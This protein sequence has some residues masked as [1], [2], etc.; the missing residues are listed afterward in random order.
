MS[1]A[2]RADSRRSGA[3]EGGVPE[4][5]WRRLHP[6]SPIIDAWKAL[7]ALFAILVYQNAE[8][9][10]DALN[11]EVA[12]DLGASRVI[13]IGAGGVLAFLLVAAGY[14]YLA[15]RRAAFAVTGGAVHYRSGVLMRTLK[16]ARLE[17]IQAVD[18][19]HPLLGRIFGLGRINIEVAGG[20]DS[21]LAFGYLPSDQLEALR[22]EIL[23]RAAGVLVDPA[24]GVD[25]IDEGGAALPS[26]A[27]SSARPLPAPVAPER[28]LYRVPVGRL[29]GSIVLNVGMIVGLLVSLGVVIGSIIA[30]WKFGAAGFSGFA[31]LI[32]GALAAVSFIW[33]RFAGEFDFT[34]AVSPDG[35]RTR[36]G[37]LETR[38][39][40]IPPRR[41]HAVRI[42]RPWLWRRMGWYRVTITQAGYAGRGEQK[43]GQKNAVD[44]LLPVGTRADAVLALW[45]VVRDLGVADPEAFIAAALDGAGDGEGFVAIPDRARVLDPFARKRR[46]FA[47]TDACLVLR[48]GWL[49][50]D[51]SV[52]PVERLQ[53]I[54]ISQGPWERRLDLVDVEAEIVPGQTP[55]IARHVDAARGLA[56]VE[57]LRERSRARR[58]A[59]PPERWMT[60]VA[61]RLDAE[62][63]TEV[64]GGAPIDEAGAA[65]AESPNG[66]PSPS[67]EVG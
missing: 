30:I 55:R 6:I 58:G 2:N 50:W 1:A 20:G 61:E 22:A 65:A 13:L 16:Q 38:S 18:I 63:R 32:F 21:N 19:H 24:P 48:D 5:R 4:G 11:S 64:L 12:K 7:A 3:V 46:A 42:V 60:R 8:L 49:T 52:I 29:I 14:S 31:S 45:L 57:E 66:D 40:T 27:G 17:R 51:A 25:P 9:L 26:G 36:S 56:L 59:E 35:I 37:L 33:R 23:A 44:V 62:G 41:V 47:L 39:Q 15:W 34:A 54:E 53:S 43:D 10:S 67:E 28:V